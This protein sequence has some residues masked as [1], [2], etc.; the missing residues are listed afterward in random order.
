MAKILTLNLPTIAV[1]HGHT[2]AGGWFLASVHDFV[3]SSSSNKRAFWQ[4]SELNIGGSI[5]QGYTGM[6]QHLMKPQVGR[7]AMWGDKYTPVQM[8]EKEVVHFL[9]KDNQEAEAFI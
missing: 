1:T 6:M 2:I 3:I 9:F 4:L 7:Q 5:P 8:V